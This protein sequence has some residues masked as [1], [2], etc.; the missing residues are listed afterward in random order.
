MVLGAPQYMAP[1]LL[2]GRLPHEGATPAAI[3]QAQT[4]QPPLPL[5]SL[6][7]SLPAGVVVAVQRRLARDLRQRH[8]SCLAFA[9]AVLAASSTAPSALE[10]TV[11]DLLLII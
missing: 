7:P 5:S 8:D 4:T 3:F 10:L 2:G 6:C 9:R 11:T 1:E